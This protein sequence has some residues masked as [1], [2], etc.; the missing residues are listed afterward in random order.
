VAPSGNAQKATEILNFLSKAAAVSEEDLA[1]LNS[2][3]AN[4][5]FKQ[6][7]LAQ[8]FLNK[9]EAV[10]PAPIVKGTT[11]T[12]QRV[13]NESDA[14]KALPDDLVY[15]PAQ[16]LKHVLLEYAGL[17]QAVTA[18]E[19]CQ[20]R[21]GTD[22]TPIKDADVPPRTT[23]P[24]PPD[25][26][27]DDLFV[28]T[29]HHLSAEAVRRFLNVFRVHWGRSPLHPSVS[30]DE[31]SAR[32]TIIQNGAVINIIDAYLGMMSELIQK[33]VKHMIRDERKLH[34]ERMAKLSTDLERT[35]TLLAQ[36][37]PPPP[38]PAE[39]ERTQALQEVERHQLQAKYATATLSTEQLDR[40]QK[41]VQNSE[42][43]FNYENS[44]RH[45]RVAASSGDAGAPWSEA[46]S[47]QTLQDSITADSRAASTEPSPQRVSTQVSRMEMLRVRKIQELEKIW[48]QLKLGY[49]QKISLHDK[50]NNCT[51]ELKVIDAALRLY[52]ECLTA[53]GHREGIVE[54]L[55]V[56]ESS[57]NADKM[58]KTLK[59]HELFAQ[60][61]TAGQRCEL[62]AKRLF[63]ETGDELMY[64]ST[65]YL[66]RMKNDF[67]QLSQLVR[68]A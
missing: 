31:A 22:L 26:S 20:K 55:H 59:R 4:L 18:K 54:Q 67:Q 8:R 64:N 47:S 43:W 3:S 61:S 1:H 19:K 10:L 63:H 34:G 44:R 6:R 33:K 16:R 65:P 39:A 24:P 5:L 51:K 62:L 29:V 42:E 56:L 40:L 68:S 11:T 49:A 2:Q 9:F 66:S 57:T 52:R 13:N 15:C 12:Q 36:R 32:A 60:L 38:N 50:W 17:L 35:N 23:P 46:G 37:R 41:S 58:E 48:T 30:E 14:S 45:L 53:V 27:S 28:P 7:E 21:R 25:E